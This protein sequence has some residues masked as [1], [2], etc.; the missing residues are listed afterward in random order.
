MIKFYTA[1][2]GNPLRERRAVKEW[3]HK[4]AKQG[5]HDMV[6]LSYIFC[7]DE[8]LLALNREH[9]QHDYYTDIITFPIELTEGE[10]HGECYISIDRVRDNAKEIRSSFVDELHRVMAHG[11]W[12]LMG[13]G[14]KS[15]A[16]EAAMRKKE[17]ESLALRMFHVEQGKA[18]G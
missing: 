9:L 3:L 1:D 12:H 17:D 10:V 5:K 8:F 18:K 4:V 15:S 6:S 11:L 14:D 7:S 16:E 2:V 13:Q